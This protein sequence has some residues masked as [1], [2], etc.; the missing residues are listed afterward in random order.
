MK[1]L[2]LLRG[3]ARFEAPGRIRVGDEVLE[4]PRI[5]LN[6]G[7]RAAIPDLQGLRDAPYLTNTDMVALETVPRQDFRIKRRAYG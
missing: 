6:V 1:G 4:A 5:F 7:G 3:H 2:T